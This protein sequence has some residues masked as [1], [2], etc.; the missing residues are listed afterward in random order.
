MPIFFDQV[1]NSIDCV[2]VNFT[3]STFPFFVTQIC[4]TLKKLPTP[5]TD[6]L[7]THHIT[8]NFGNF[9][10]YGVSVLICH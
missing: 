10:I 7:D 5:S 1:A 6:H 9:S 8:I 3:Q 4:S 2:G